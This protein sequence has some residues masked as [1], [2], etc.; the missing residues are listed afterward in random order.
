ME[1]KWI[2]HKGKQILFVDYRGAKDDNDMLTMLYQE[3]EIE[4]K[5]NFKV[6]VLSNFTGIFPQAKY[7]SEVKRLGKEI[8]NDKTTKTALLGIDGLKSLLVQGYIA[9]TGDKSLK[10]FDNEEVAKDWLIQ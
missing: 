2:E 10:T 8:R 5:A 4:K 6:P 7:L 9:F 1:T 3:V